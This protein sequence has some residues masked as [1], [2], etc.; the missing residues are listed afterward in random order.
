MWLCL[1]SLS[2]PER[3]WPVL[4]NA[5][6]IPSCFAMAD[7]RWSD[8]I[9]RHP[10]MLDR[11]SMLA[12]RHVVRRQST[13]CLMARRSPV[14]SVSMHSFSLESLACLIVYVNWERCDPTM[15][16]FLPLLSCHWLHLWLSA[17]CLERFDS[18]FLRFVWD[19]PARRPNGSA[20][21]QDKYARTWPADRS[22]P[23]S[24]WFS[25]WLWPM[26]RRR[27]MMTII[28]ELIRCAIVLACVRPFSSLQ[29]EQLSVD[30]HSPLSISRSKISNL[31]ETSIR[32]EFRSVPLVSNSAAKLYRWS[33]SLLYTDPGVVFSLF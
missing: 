10:T 17:W 32:S 21:Q 3:S 18:G 14:R 25:S 6:N 27:A 20:H 22:L 19:T 23:M 13:V 5:L 1:L 26:T 9:A 2:S 29:P 8:P 4:C 11:F 12:R 16:R 24:I 15:S 33:S 28:V 30:R 7:I 31:R